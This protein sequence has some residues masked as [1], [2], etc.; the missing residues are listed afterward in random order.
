MIK[1]EREQKTILIADDSSF[2]RMVIKE[3]LCNVGYENVIFATSATEILETCKGSKLDIV[4]LDMNLSDGDGLNVLR[5]IRLMHP[6]LK[7]IIVSAIDQ[8]D[9]IEKAKNLG[10]LDYVIK[11]FRSER[12]ISAVDD[13]ITGKPANEKS[14][15]EGAANA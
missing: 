1:K 10:A 8:K 12:L 9:I 14:S 4:L 3:M 13:A 15:L 6:D 7:C 5:K 2:I 11:P